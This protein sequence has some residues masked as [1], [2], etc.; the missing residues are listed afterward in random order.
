MGTYIAIDALHK[1]G[2]TKRKINIDEYMNKM[3]EKRM[4]MV[5][6]YVRLNGISEQHFRVKLHADET[7]NVIQNMQYIVTVFILIWV[8][9]RNQSFY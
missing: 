1:E 3:S 4:K 9:T 5:Q 8:L 7:V 2:Y 6:T